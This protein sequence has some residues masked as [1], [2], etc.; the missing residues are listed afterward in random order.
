MIPRAYERSF[1]L[2]ILAVKNAQDHMLVIRNAVACGGG[3]K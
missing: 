1:S 3:F 2:R